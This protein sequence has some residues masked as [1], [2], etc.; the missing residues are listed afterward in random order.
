MTSPSV[1]PRAR[2]K[3]CPISIPDC[4]QTVTACARFYRPHD[5]H[6]PEIQEQDVPGAGGR[7]REHRG[8]GHRAAGRVLRPAVAV[9][10]RGPGNDN[11]GQPGGR[12]VPAVF[13]P[14]RGRVPD[15]GRGRRRNGQR[16][17]A[18]R[19]LRPVFGGQGPRRQAVRRRAVHAGQGHFQ[20]VRRH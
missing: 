7:V 15:V 10:A 20:D 12:H 19:G 8:T 18:R 1:V 11:G 9:R 13:R 4:A 17:A 6:D 5:A 2:G 16:G 3:W 14:V